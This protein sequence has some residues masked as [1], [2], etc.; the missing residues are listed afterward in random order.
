MTETKPVWASKRMIGSVV[1]IVA[2]LAG[3]VGYSIGPDE[4]LQL[5]EML[6]TIANN[7]WAVIAGVG[8]L[9]NL[10]GSI[11]A[12]HRLTLTGS[13]GEDNA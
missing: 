8:W 2:M 6:E 9:I 5:T 7:V 3:L 12:K 13:G 4:Q 10:W 1:M 11:V